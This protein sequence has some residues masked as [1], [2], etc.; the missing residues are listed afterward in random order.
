MVSP[1][2]TFIPSVATM[3]FFGFNSTGSLL[4]AIAV[5]S[6]SDMMMREWYVS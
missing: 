1:S 3:S 6:A 5:Q 4:F 2:V